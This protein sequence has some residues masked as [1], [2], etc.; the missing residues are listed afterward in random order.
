MMILFHFKVAPIPKV[1][2][3]TLPIEHEL[4]RKLSLFILNFSLY[5]R[6]KR[7][8]LHCQFCFLWSF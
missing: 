3:N 7:E 8:K 2:T 1:F 4:E 5:H 6:R